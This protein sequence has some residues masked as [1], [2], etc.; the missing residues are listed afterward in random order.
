MTVKEIR[1]DLQETRYYYTHK[2]A[3]D[4]AV[5]LIGENNVVEKVERYNKIFQK[6][7]ARMYDI[8]NSILIP[9]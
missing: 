1:E 4:G 3:F 6:A 9:K 2:A 8:H 5:K 7:P